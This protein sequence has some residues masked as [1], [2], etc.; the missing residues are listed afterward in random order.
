MAE[1]T[2]LQEQLYLWLISTFNKE[3]IFLFCVSCIMFFAI[4]SM[5]VIWAKDNGQFDNLEE[6]KFEMMEGCFSTLNGSPHI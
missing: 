3:G 6:A 1:V 4:A 5:I 2:N